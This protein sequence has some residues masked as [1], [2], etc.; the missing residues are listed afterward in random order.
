MKKQNPVV[1]YTIKG[2]T[3]NKF[4][5]LDI[6]TGTGIYYGFKIISSSV[7]VGILGSIV[8]TEG[9]KRLPSKQLRC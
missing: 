4:L 2:S 5:I 8:F 7:L 9:I 6:I 1:F 3:I